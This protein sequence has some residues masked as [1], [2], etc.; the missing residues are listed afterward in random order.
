MDLARAVRARR[1]RCARRAGRA[2]RRPRR[3]A[4]PPRAAPRPFASSTMSPRAR[5]WR[6]A[7]AHASRRRAQTSSGRSTRSSLSSILR[8]ALRLL[9]LLPGDVLADEVFGLVD[10]RL[11]P[12]GELALAL[13]VVLAGDG[14]VA[15]SAA[16]RCGSCVRPSSIVA[17]ADG[18][19]ERA[20]VRDDEHRAARSRRGAARAR[21]W[22]RDR[23]GWWA[24]R[25]AGDRAS[26][27]STAPRWSRPRSPPESGATAR[28][29]DRG[30]GK[31]SSRAIVATRCSRASPPRAW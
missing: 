25:A 4:R 12:L 19:E 21:R 14:V 2:D 29:E 9:G 6:E 10:E 22:C 1:C 11:L 17:G 18:V 23:G 8:R 16:D 3:A 26:R 5:R 20:I 13:E 28:V 30:R 27:A 15:C 24:R 7:E 31:P